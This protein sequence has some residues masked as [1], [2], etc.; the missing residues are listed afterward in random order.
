M[1]KPKISR[2]LL[3]HRL[4]REFP[5]RPR[6]CGGVRARLQSQVVLLHAV[7][8]SPP[9]EQA[10]VVMGRPSLSRIALEERLKA[11]AAGLRRTDPEVK[12]L[13]EEDGT[14][15]QVILKTGEG[16]LPVLLVLGVHGSHRGMEHR[17]IGSRT[18]KPLLTVSGPTLS[19][20]AHLLGAV[21]LTLELEEI[22]YCSDFL[23]W[24]D[25]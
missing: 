21:N 19:V 12:T 6:L 2:I 14:P 15:C 18:G 25:L 1:N 7:E 20:S 16:D 10:E 24:S 17:L 9:A 3:C 22:L 4:P 13:V 5:T 23:Q 8:L 11:F